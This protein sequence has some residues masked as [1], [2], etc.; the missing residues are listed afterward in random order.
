MSVNN[1]N[2]FD[3]EKVVPSKQ[4]HDVVL[5]LQRCY[6]VKTMSRACWDTVLCN[7]SHKQPENKAS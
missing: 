6:N 2:T 7:Y 3:V 5:T 1:W 4:A